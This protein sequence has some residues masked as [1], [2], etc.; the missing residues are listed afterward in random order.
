MQ[1]QSNA[2]AG[3]LVPGRELAPFA[4]HREGGLGRFLDDLEQRARRPA[5][6]ALALLPIAHGL[7]RNADPRRK[8]GLGEAGAAADIA[9]ISGVVERASA[10]RAALCAAVAIGPRV[11]GDGALAAVGQHFD[12]TSVGFQSHAQHGAR[13]GACPG[14]WA[15]RIIADSS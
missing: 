7:D 11:A 10:A 6:R 5:W 14:I 1:F 9:G 4:E 15:R 2:A 8:G 3:E 13:S 12:Q